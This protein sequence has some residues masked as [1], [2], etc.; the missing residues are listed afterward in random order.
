MRR[1]LH[2]HALGYW[3]VFSNLR[4]VGQSVDDFPSLLS[5]HRHLISR[6]QLARFGVPKCRIKP[7][8]HADEKAV[9]LRHPMLALQLEVVFDG[10]CVTVQ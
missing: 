9:L 3:I 2:P 1:L 6:R 10:A 5:L 8:V 4:K 7:I